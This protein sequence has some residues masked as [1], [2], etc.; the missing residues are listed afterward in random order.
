[1]ES[2]AD[3][4]G[5]LLVVLWTEDDENDRTMIE[6]A[7]ARSDRHL[8]LVF[9]SDGEAAWDYLSGSG[10]YA[11]RSQN[12]LPH[13]IVTDLKMPRCNGFELV[14]RIRSD[15]NLKHLPVYVFSASD[16]TVDRRAAQRIGVDGYITK[17]T[18]FGLWSTTVIGMLDQAAE[19]L[20]AA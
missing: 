12:P 1:M 18:G 20:H 8:K 17:P 5:D 4:P 7:L 9:V 2:T 19:R 13:V 6:L 3:R 10:D 15:A 14:E 11:E 16:L